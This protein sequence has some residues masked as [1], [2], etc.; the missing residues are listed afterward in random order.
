MPTQ[1]ESARKGIITTEMEAA[2][3]SEGI[4]AETLRCGIASGEIVLP[5]NVNHKHITPLAVG[6]GLSTKVNANIGTSDACF[7][8]ANELNKLEAA[9]QAGA[10]AVMDL[11]TGGD[12]DAIRRVV[13]KNSAV[14]VGTVPLY[15][16][17]LDGEGKGRSMVEMTEADIFNA[18]GKHCADGVDFI[19]VHCGVTRGVIDV[20]RQTGRVMDIVSRGGSFMTAWML[21]NNKENP[22]FSQF[23]QLLDLAKKYDVT[24]SLGDS[25]RPGCLEDASDA[26]QIQELLILGGL[27][28]RSREA[29]VQ[30]MVEGPGHVPM[31]QI[32]ANMVL[33]KTLCHNAPFYVL[34]PIVT[35]VAPGYDHITSAI[36]G[37]MAA[38]YGADFLCYV[39]PAEHLGL[40]SVD[41]VREGVI[42]SRIAAHAAD[43]VK[44]VKGAREWD[45]KMALAR[46]ELNWE[47]Q[48]ALAIDPIKASKLRKEKNDDSQECCT[49]CGKFCAY[50]IVSEYL[51]TTYERG[52]N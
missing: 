26:A 18:I 28:K 43:I 39:T 4:A 16:A 6:K 20:L 47:Q 15:Q 40:P 1:L 11:S 50:K 42:A 36:G 23:D 51:G 37:A 29:G 30:V 46:K 32:Q 27:V 5:C 21:H 22:L 10:H 49:M 48:I 38:S 25:L 2:S 13:I 9:L 41:D 19:T 24:L 8:L 3:N 52:C 45:K 14:M 7:E 35:D 33:E 31:D 12:I 44:G 34:G 17:L